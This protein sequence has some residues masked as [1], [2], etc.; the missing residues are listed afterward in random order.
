MI[1]V[2]CGNHRGQQSTRSIFF[3]SLLTV[4]RIRM[5]F[6][7]KPSATEGETSLK[8][9]LIRLSRFGGVKEQINK[10]T[11]KLTDKDRRVESTC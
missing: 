1:Y 9:Q 11:D 4:R 7:L 3:I 5:F 2:E 6:S 10:Q 8:F